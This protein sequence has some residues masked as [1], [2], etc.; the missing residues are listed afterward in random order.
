MFVDDTVN[1]KCGVTV[2]V[3]VDLKALNEQTVTTVMWGEMFHFF[4]SR[5]VSV[6]LKQQRKIPP[7]PPLQCVQPSACC[8]Y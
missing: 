3:A 8:D 2:C 7:Q 1:T 4:R 5:A 6:E